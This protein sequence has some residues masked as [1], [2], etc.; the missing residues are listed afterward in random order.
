VLETVRLLS[1][2]ETPSNKLMQIILSGQP[3]MA[4]KLAQPGLAQLRQRLAVLV[5]LDPLSPAETANYIAHRLQV[6][7]HAG[8]RL[9]S[10]SALDVIAECS[11][12]IPR[13]V[14]NICRSALSLGCALGRTRIDPEI[15][16]LSAADLSLDPLIPP[17][18]AIL[19]PALPT[20]VEQPPP[21]DLQAG[22]RLSERGMLRRIGVRALLAMTVFLL[23]SSAAK[24]Q[25]QNQ[26]TTGTLAS[27]PPSVEPAGPDVGLTMTSTQTIAPAPASAFPERRTS[28]GSM[29]TAAPLVYRV[30]PNDTLEQISLRSMGRYDTNLLQ[31]WQQLNPEL[32]DPDLILVGQ[33]LRLPPSAH[34][35][36]SSGDQGPERT[37]E[38]APSKQ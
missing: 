17:R 9:F 26:P 2:F 34:T 37:T 23:V 28:P 25:S 21:A 4:A 19:R 16:Q 31:K 20:P 5:K 27:S 38:R 29:K 35:T 13:N 33:R 30:V 3:H 22:K 32:T 8:G 1:D 10:R 36:A 15:I 12:G 6:A 24:R 7:G 18:R 11:Q 14:N